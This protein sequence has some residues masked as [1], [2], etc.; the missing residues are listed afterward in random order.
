M[1]RGD[2]AAVL[3]AFLLVSLVAG[4][5]AAASWPR[6]KPRLW[7]RGGATTAAFAAAVAGGSNALGSRSPRPGSCRVIGLVGGMASGKST[8]AQL[9]RERGAVV[10]DA[11]KSVL[12]T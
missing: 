8:V 12:S 7:D 11:D 3:S 1:S 5:W 9:L 6:P 10:I 2:A 4:A